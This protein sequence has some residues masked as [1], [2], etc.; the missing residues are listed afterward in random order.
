MKSTWL[1]SAFFIFYIKQHMVSKFATDTSAIFFLNLFL[2]LSTFHFDFLTPQNLLSTV[3]A[4]GLLS[5]RSNTITGYST[6]SGGLILRISKAQ[7]LKVTGWIGLYPYDPNGPVA[8][9]LSPR[10]PQILLRSRKNAFLTDLSQF[11]RTNPP[12]NGR[13]KNVTP[14]RSIRGSW[15][16]PINNW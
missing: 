13:I 5:L 8:P 7:G 1:L 14:F 12:K 9:D 16:S 11:T 2:L 10:R 15:R 4:S 6:F 3:L